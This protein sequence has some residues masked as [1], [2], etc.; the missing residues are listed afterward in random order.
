MANDPNP[1]EVDPYTPRTPDGQPIT[2]ARLYASQRTSVPLDLS[3]WI[4]RVLPQRAHVQGGPPTTPSGPAPPSDPRPSPTQYFPVRDPANPSLAELY[5]SERTGIPIDLGPWRAQVF[6]Q[7]A[8]RQPSDPFY[9]PTASRSSSIAGSNT[10]TGR[11]LSMSWPARPASAQPPP[12]QVNAPPYGGEAGDVLHANRLGPSAGGPPAPLFV[13]SSPPT[14]DPTNRWGTMALLG[15]DKGAFDAAS[16][17]L[18]API[19]TPTATAPEAPPIAAAAPLPESGLRRE[20]PTSQAKHLPNVQAQL[21]SVVTNPPLPTIPDFQEKEAAAASDAPRIY[22]VDGYGRVVRADPLTPGERLKGTARAFAQGATGDLWHYLEAGISAKLG[23]EPRSTRA[24][25]D[26]EKAFN[27]GGIGGKVPTWDSAIYSDHLADIQD[28]S[29][30][31]AAAYPQEAAA[32]WAVGAGSTLLLAPEARAAL[33]AGDLRAAIPLIKKIAPKLGV[34]AAEMQGLEAATGALRRPGLV[35]DAADTSRLGEPVAGRV[36]KIA[37][38]TGSQYSVAREVN[39]G[40]TTNPLGIRWRHFREAN[41]SLLRDMED[42]PEFRRLLK[43]QLG[44]E[45]ARTKRGLAPGRSPAGY[46]WHHHAT[47]PGVMQ[48]V[49]REQHAWGSIFQKTLHPG[50]KGGMSKWGH[51]YTTVP[52]GELWYDLQ[53]DG[54]ANPATGD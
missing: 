12:G 18:R 46:T 5:A 49:P 28:E 25:R 34:E 47:R 3:A 2:L 39:L 40:P 21:P 36:A 7:A 1:F 45:L 4:A 8:Q 37:V 20:P 26:A 9:D 50:G 44:I 10:T 15:L 24:R 38:P 16:A 17:D 19:T 29:E 51:L 23:T 11:P 27:S 14:P 35:N 33:L 53:P 54:T 43:E 6:P 41:E 32:A 13:S 31:F 42:Y 30:K 48:L 22:V 52:G